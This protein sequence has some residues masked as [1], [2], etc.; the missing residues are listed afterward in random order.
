MATLDEINLQRYD[1]LRN[2]DEWIDDGEMWMKL[3]EKTHGEFDTIIDN[4][5]RRAGWVPLTLH[6]DRCIEHD[7]WFGV[8]TYDISKEDA[9]TKPNIID[10]ENGDIVNC[11]MCGEFI[12]AKGMEHG[13]A[14]TCHHCGT[15]Q[16]VIQINFDDVKHLE[17]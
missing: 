1:F 6:P 4:Q 7:R 15:I 2:I 17:L 11:D 10:F 5:M 8:N 14:L 16:Y 13:D 12:D 3:G 9:S